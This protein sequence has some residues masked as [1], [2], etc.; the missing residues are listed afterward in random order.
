VTATVPPTTTPSLKCGA[1]WLERPLSDFCY[2]FSTNF[3]TF[4]KANEA[5]NAISGSLLAITSIDEQ[6]F[7]QSILLETQIDSENIS[8]IQRCLRFT[9]KWK[10][11][12]DRSLQRIVSKRLELVRQIISIRLFELGSNGHH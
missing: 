7:I 5:C 4:K 8:R 10:V 3:E 12:L 1:N 6:L 2:H 11:L 9:A